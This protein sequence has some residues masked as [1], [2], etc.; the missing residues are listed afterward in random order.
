MTPSKNALSQFEKGGRLSVELVTSPSE[1]AQTT[2][3]TKR[4]HRSLIWHGRAEMSLFN[5][6]MKVNGQNQKDA[7]TL[8]APVF[9]S[10]KTAFIAI[11][12]LRTLSLSIWEIGS[13]YE[14]ND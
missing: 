8:T 11:W 10:K 4:N 14:R 12:N 9:Y 6:T 13:G 3:T 5:E 7:S 2:K 1:K